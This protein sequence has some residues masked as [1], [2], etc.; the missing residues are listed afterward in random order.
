M[1]KQHKTLRSVI[2]PYAAK[3]ISRCWVSWFRLRLGRK[4]IFGAN[5]ETN[6]RLVVRG[7]GRV[8]FGDNI[9]AWAHAEKNVF[10]TYTPDSIIKVGSNTRLNGAGVMAYTSIEFGDNCILGSTVVFDSDFHPLD[11]KQ[12]H[13]PNA[14]VASK[15]IK[16]GN[17]VWLGGQTAVLKGVT[18][19]DN[20]VVAFRGV[21]PSDVP[22]NVVV[23]GN[24]AKIIKRFE[25]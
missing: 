22:A 4:V 13:N 20:S 5:F 24:P 10:I 23:G 15:P 17:N 12:R 8:I 21:V 3:I 6:G 7:P 19:G 14:P 25:E 9:K 16:V 18:I 2:K 1:A 11:P